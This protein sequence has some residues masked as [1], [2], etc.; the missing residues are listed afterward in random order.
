[1]QLNERAKGGSKAHCSIVSEEGTEQWA[2]MAFPSN[3]F[4]HSLLGNLSASLTKL[5]ALALDLPALCSPAQV[6]SLPEMPFVC[7]PHDYLLP[8]LQTPP[9]RPLLWKDF[10]DSHQ[11]THPLNWGSPVSLCAAVLNPW[12]AILSWNG[13]LSTLHCGYLHGRISS[14]SPDLGLA[15]CFHFNSV[16]MS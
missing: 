3:P 14:P 5:F 6:T 7:N 1:M 2:P 13:S 15:T 11:P 4:G 10:S 9:L 12:P 16:S 8:F